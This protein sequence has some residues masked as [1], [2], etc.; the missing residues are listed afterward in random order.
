VITRCYSLSDL[1]VPETYRI[2][3]KRV[4]APPDR[5]EAPPGI[6]SA[7]L[8]DNVQE[9][10]VIE[11]RAPAGQFFLDPDPT[12]PVVLVSGGIGITPMMSML[13]WS[14]DEQPDRVIYLFHG[15]RHG[16]EHAFKTALEGFARLRAN[17][18]L[19]IVYSRPD[20]D[21]IL[22][23]DFQHAGHVDIALLKRMLPQG[24]H[25]FYV[26]GPPAMM[27]SLV[28]ALRTWGI[29]EQN[30]HFEAFGPASVHSTVRA[31]PDAVL[32]GTE[33]MDIAFRR[34]RRTLRWDGR[35]AS[36]LDFAERH[37]IA[38]DSGCRSGS[39]GSCETKL[40]SGTVR[41]AQKPDHDIFPGSCLLCVGVPASPLQLDA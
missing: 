35:D 29:P 11:I 30:I 33:Q 1:P 18:H 9:N 10:D 23:R 5:P 13:R 19:N 14:F 6:A 21:D 8:H 28:P 40:I 25:D 37:G 27:E 4:L 7:H 41:Y 34:S 2:T 38:V 17:F 39:C 22:G 3:V 26:C 31:L 16:R 20:P 15:L 32:V 24:K 12:I 36:L